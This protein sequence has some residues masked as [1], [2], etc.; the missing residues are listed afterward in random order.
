MK[1]SVSIKFVEFQINRENIFGEFFMEN[2]YKGENSF[3]C[4]KKGR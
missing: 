1:I 4:H 3:Q 2:F